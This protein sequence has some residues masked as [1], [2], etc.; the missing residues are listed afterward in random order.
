MKY[1]GSEYKTYLESV[2]VEKD[3][4]EHFESSD[5]SDKYNYKRLITK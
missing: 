2:D 5:K 3:W 1:S 4:N